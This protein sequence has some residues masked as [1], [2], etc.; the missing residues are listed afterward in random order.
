GNGP[1]RHRARGA[2]YRER[3]RLRGA[4]VLR[5]DLGTLASS[6]DP[7]RYCVRRGSRGPGT[8][9]R[10]SGVFPEGAFLGGSGVFVAGGAALRMYGR[11]LRVV[12][13]S[14]GSRWNSQ[15]RYTLPSGE[16]ITSGALPKGAARL[17]ELSA[18]ASKIVEPLARVTPMRTIRP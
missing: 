9:G 2:R 1:R 15:W 10:S 13:A 5:H 18:T 12:Q 8:G 7:A 16:T 14:N 17:T 6:G 3:R 11:A 4:R